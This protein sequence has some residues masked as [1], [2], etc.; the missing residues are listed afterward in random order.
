MNSKQTPKT[1]ATCAYSSYYD[2]DMVECRRHAPKAPLA[3]GQSPFPTMG[4]GDSC[5][6]YEQKNESE[7]VNVSYKFD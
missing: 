4:R 2:S 1:C 6:D 5:G 3:E 7:Q